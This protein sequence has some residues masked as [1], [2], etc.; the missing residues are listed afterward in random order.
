MAWTIES[1]RPCP[2]PWLVRAAPSRWKGC[3]RRSSSLGSD[4]RAVVGHRQDGLSRLGRGR[5]VDATAGHV[6]RDRVV[7]EVRHETLDEL[8]V[9][10]HPGRV[11]RGVQTQATAL[12]LWTASG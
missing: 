11:E 7:E 5:D 4:H 1:P 6:V 3:W 2:S 10:L 8:R 9:A 12:D